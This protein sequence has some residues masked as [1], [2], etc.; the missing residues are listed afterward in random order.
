ME[1]FSSYQNGS[2][3]REQDFQKLSQ[4]IG[5]S[6]QKISQ[7]VSS[8]QR[9]VNQVGTNQDSPELRKQLHNIQ[10]YT[11][12]LVKDTN[13]YL[14]DLQTVPSSV[15]QSEQRQRKMQKERLQDE[16][17][18]VLNLFQAAQRSAASKEKDLVNKARAQA[19]GDPF[20]PPYKKDNQ[21]IELQDSSASRQ[22]QQVQSLQEEAD[23]RALEEQEQSIRQL[24]SDINDVN[25]I[26]KELGAMVHEQGEIV[27]SIE[28]SVEHTEH[29]VSE[30]VH[31]L[32]EAS[33]YKN[34]IRRKKVI[35]ALIAAIVLTVIILIIVYS[36]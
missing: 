6:I 18:S 13:G 23:L 31:Q 16:F 27:D 26:F 17:T 4:T 15:S 9:M 30:G 11:Q 8:M 10:H 7:N 34:K 20:L 35:I 12:Q 22:Q 24:E 3:N 28:A 29:Y 14:K 21:L 1:S 19:F 33:N 25:Q 32:H 2:S 5:S 36:R